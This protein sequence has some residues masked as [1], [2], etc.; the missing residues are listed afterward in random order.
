MDNYHEDLNSGFHSM[1]EFFLERP[2]QLKL[3]PAMERKAGVFHMN[4]VS[5]SGEIE[6]IEKTKGITDAK[7]LAEDGLLEYLLPV[8]ASQRSVFKDKGDLESLAA[9]DLS[10][11]DIR[12]MRDTELVA[13]A[14]KV[15]KLATANLEPLGEHKVNEATIAELKARLDDYSKKI[16]KSI[17]NPQQKGEMRKAVFV[18]MSKMRE[19]LEDMDDVVEAYQRLDKGFYDQYCAL[20]PV[21]RAGIRHRKPGNDTPEP[22]KAE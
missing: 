22:P 16:G 19:M 21:K 18:H 10:D 11:S 1:D 12:G 14:G 8:R 7:N 20:R 15:I 13:F 3:V 9:V 2:D 5:L 4:F 17:G 6:D